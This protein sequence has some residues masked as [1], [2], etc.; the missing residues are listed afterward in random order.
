M[1][2]FL[3]RGILH[4]VFTNIDTTTYTASLSATATGNSKDEAKIECEKNL[5]KTFD[6]YL[7]DNQ[8]IKNYTFETDY[9]E[10]S[11]DN[12]FPSSEQIKRVQEYLDKRNL[13]SQIPFSGCTFGNAFN[14]N[15]VF[16][17]SGNGG[18]NGEP[19]DAS[20]YWRWAS[21]TKI[22]GLVTISAALEDGIISSLD[23]P[24]YNYI[25]EI[26]N[27]TSYVSDSVK[28]TGFDAFG[29]PKYDQILTTDPN[30]GKSITIKMCLESSIG[31][32]YSI[33]GL[34]ASRK[35]L[36]D[37][38]QGTKSGQNYIAW[39]QNIEKNNGYAD[40]ITSA[41]DDNVVTVTEAII[42]RTK[43][44]LL[45]KPGTTNVYDTG[46]TI[47]CAVLHTAL[48]K[49][50]INLTAAEYAKE[51]IFNQINMNKS[52]LYSGSLNPPEDVLSKLTNAFFVR[53]DTSPSISGSDQKGPNVL[54]NTMYGVFD[55]NADGDGFKSQMYDLIIKPKIPN[56][57]T[58]DRYAGGFD[59]AG[60]GTLSD[61]CK[62][63]KLLINK[64]YC[65]ETQ[66]QVLTN[67]T[68]EWLLTGKYSNA[69]KA[70]GLCIPNSEL[71]N[72]LASSETWC[73]GVGK[74]LD[75]TNTLPPGFGPNTFTW[76]GYFGTTFIFDTQS[77][78]Y[79]VSGTQV[80]GSSWLQTNVSFQPDANVIWAIF[81]NYNFMF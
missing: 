40:G 24:I 77:G 33:W 73:C 66:T 63:M 64:G 48:K 9:S 28:G 51:R 65:P 18:P 21:M 70:I 62:I 55:K 5:F 6:K 53:K 74:Y 27:I 54:Y 19:L 69:Q 46:I 60:C 61:F 11:N 72:L 35:N 15:E 17:G 23:E 13:D 22:I 79:L 26:A 30:L 3:C 1:S 50:G 38:F 34:G 75:N 41:Y 80:S 36:V 68:T 39:L 59:A 56:Y 49:K 45:C 20:M 52:W 43:Y 67:Q 29:T 57:S 37:S 42:E 16:I 2:N 12:V 44:P 58:N 8:Q 10:S 4:G 71:Y 81:N 25:P 32:G 47:A 14:G 31:F 76:G 7:L 78:N